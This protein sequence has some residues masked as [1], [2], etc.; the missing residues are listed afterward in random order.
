VKTHFHTFYTTGQNVKNKWKH[1][2][3]NFRA[4]LNIMNANKSGDSG[5]SPSKRESRWRCFKML[6]FFKFFEC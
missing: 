4:E 2:R 3:D 6:T 1:F 5:L